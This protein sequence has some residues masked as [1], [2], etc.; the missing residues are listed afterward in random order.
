[1]FAIALTVKRKGKLGATVKKIVPM[2][3]SYADSRNNL[4]SRNNLHRS[5][6][7]SQRQPV[8]LRRL[9]SRT[10]SSS[11]WSSSGKKSAPNHKHK[12]ISNPV[13]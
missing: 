3:K 4:Y 12:Q 8:S 1:V 10:S 9:H 13:A 7:L 6:L 2:T 11:P 5:N